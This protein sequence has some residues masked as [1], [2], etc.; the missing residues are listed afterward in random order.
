MLHFNDSGPGGDLTNIQA[1]SRPGHAKA[2]EDRQEFIISSRRLG[3]RR[4]SEERPKK[5]G[6][7][8]GV[9]CA[10]QVINVLRKY[11]RQF[12]KGISTKATMR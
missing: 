2:R 3:I 10:M 5:I 6:I 8:Y 1:T 9:S 11:N 4:N 12:V 7:V